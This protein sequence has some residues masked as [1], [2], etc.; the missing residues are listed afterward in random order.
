[1]PGGDGGVEA[2]Q[3]DGAVAEGVEGAG[4]DEA[5]EGALVPLAQVEAFAQVV[6]PGEG[7]TLHAFGDQR[8]DGPVADEFDAREAEADGGGAVLACLKGEAGA[9]AVHVGRADR[10]TEALAL[11]D[12]L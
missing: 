9:A 11:V 4:L 12:R 2:R 5:F 7:T 8:L 1:M 3:D 6:E 10:H